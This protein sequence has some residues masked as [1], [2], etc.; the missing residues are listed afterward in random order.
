MRNRKT[1]L[2]LLGSLMLVFMAACG[3]GISGGGASG[4]S[5]EAAS[6]GNAAN[7][8]DKAKAANTSAPSDANNNGTPD[9]DFDMGGRTVKWVSW[10]DESIK[11]DNPDNIQRKKNLDD[12][13]KKHNFKIDYVVLDYGQYKDKVTAS[14]LSGEPVGDIIRLARPWMIPSLVKQ[15]LFWPVDEYTKNK[16]VFIQQYTNEYSEYNGRGYGFRSGI[17]GASSGI[18][19]NRT[20]MNQLGLKNLQEDVNN[21]NW[22][23]DT[24]IQAAKDANKDSN[25]DGKLDTWGLATDSL[26]I[27]ALAANES[28]LVNENKQN[29]DDPKTIEALN[30][31][32]RIDTEHVARPTEGGDWTEPGQFFRQ[33]N[34][35]MYPGMDYEMET[36]KK[37]MPDYE[38]GFLPFPKGPSASG[39]HSYVTIPN[40]LTVPKAV[41]HPEQLVYIYEK[42]ND[43]DSIYDYPKQ[44]S[45]E[46]FFSNED[47]INNAKMAGEDIK[48]IDA[49]DGYPNM[50]YYPMLDDLRK[51][52]SVSS[53]IEKYKA[54][55]QSSIDE[56]WKK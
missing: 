41:Q 16:N 7:E 34:T 45:L 52:V 33:G 8:G 56:V 2:M 50:P 28:N 55:F 35:L 42:I 3:S 30:F 13:M 6:S 10:Y 17:N 51:G 26:L 54:Q 14:L 11:E 36:F 47:D 43:I 38:I 20:L 32:S 23:W 49:T 40:Y 9:M 39:Y 5:G 15:D 53:I 22:N 25:N 31:V 4:N 1:I 27:P 29:L 48:V 19:Y 12:L 18:F 46:T 44:A 37:D 21:D 24:F